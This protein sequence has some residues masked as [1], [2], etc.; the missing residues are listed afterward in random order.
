MLKSDG[1]TIIMNEYDYGLDLPFKLSGDVLITDKI[2]F[3]IKKNIYQEEKIIRKEFNDL[4]NE[5]GKI[6]FVLSFTEDET[7]LLHQE[8]IFIW[9]INVGI[10]KC[11]TLLLK[12]VTCLRKFE[13]D[14]LINKVKK[15]LIYNSFLIFIIKYR[16]T[17]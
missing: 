3:S 8:I 9:Y 11:I 13:T 6:V 17:C 10:A 14:A 4:A 5:D 7:K 12:M 1:K 16:F 15:E 2:V